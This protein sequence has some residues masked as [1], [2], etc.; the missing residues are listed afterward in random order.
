[1]KIV[2][3]IQISLKFVHRGPINNNQALVEIMAWYFFGAKPLLQP[4]MAKL[5]DAHMRH[6]TT[7]S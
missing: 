5:T 7:M 6:S 2:F 4:M 1:M 3:T